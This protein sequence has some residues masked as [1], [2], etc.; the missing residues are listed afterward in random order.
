MTECSL[1]FVATVLLLFMGYSARVINDEEGVVM[2]N[3]KGLDDSSKIYRH[4][5][6]IGIGMGNEDADAMRD[7]L[8]YLFTRAKNN[9]KKVGHE[10]ALGASGG[11]VGGAAVGSIA[12]PAGATLGAVKGAATGAIAGGF[13]AI[14]YDAIA[15]SSKQKKRNEDEG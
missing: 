8:N 10:I 1:L 7:T 14:V 11:A 2:K 15:E 12:G 5:R 13:K 4:K 6:Q 3:V 9:K